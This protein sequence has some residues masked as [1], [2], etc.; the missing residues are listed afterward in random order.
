MS[1]RPLVCLIAVVALAAPAF[2]ITPGDDLLIAGA[3][4]TPDW[5]SDLYINNP[6]ATTVQVQLFWLERNPETANPDPINFTIG[7]EQTLVLPDVIGNDLGL[8]RGEGAFRITSTGGEVT[9][10]LLV[11]SQKFGGTLGSGFE[12]I[13]AASATSAGET[14]FVMGLVDGDGVNDD[15]DFYTNVFALAGADGVTMDLDLVSASGAVLDT[16]TVTLD[17]YR[18]WLS[19]RTAD[20]WN[21]NGYEGTLRV[22]VSA[23]SA[24][25]LASKIDEAT[26]D[27]TT[28][29]SQFGAS[30]ASADGTY[31]FAIYDSLAFASGGNLSIDDD[32]VTV[33]NGTYSNFDKL[34]GGGSSEC[35]LVFQWG[36]GLSPTDR[37]EFEQGVE[38]IDT[39]PDPGGGEMTWTVTFTVD[40]NIGLQG[41]I[42]AEGAGFSGEDA[43]CNGTFPTLSFT[44]GKIE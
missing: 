19:F 2:A 5:V 17:A 31:H 6:G 34:D 23:G 38:I 16:A 30:V 11:Y 39:Y 7:P 13:P 25:I 26:K 9:A 42:D 40:E 32:I 1:A 29:E 8:S 15:D 4:R 14:A 3:A 22:R 10:N 37:D 43:G 27:P 18:P 35:T 44:G 24:A 12:A 41:T 20:I 21:Q 33:I 36:V 28:L